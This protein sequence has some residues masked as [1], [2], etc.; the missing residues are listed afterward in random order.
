MHEVFQYGSKASRQLTLLVQSAALVAGWALWAPAGLGELRL[1]LVYVLAVWIVAGGVTLGTYL[2][3]SVA[4]FSEL[5]VEAWL[6]SA[7]A[8]WLVPGA[9][10]LASRWPVAVAVGLAVVVNS[11]RLLVSSRP[12]KGEGIVR[13]RRAAGNPE[14]PRLFRYQPAQAVFFSKETVPPML[15][16]LVLYTGVYALAGEYP[17]LAAGSFATV[18]AIWVGMSVARGA[19][20]ARVAARVPYLAPGILLTLLWTVTLTAVLLHTEIVLEGPVAKAP[21]I[22][23]GEAPETPGMTGRVLQRLMHVPPAPEAP[24][25]V[26]AQA[27]KSVTRMVDPG[28]AIGAKDQNGVPGVVLRPRPKR[29]QRPPLIVPGAR[30][31]VA[32]GRPLVIP[33]TGE[34]QLY[35]T[36]S[37]EL[38]AG[39]IVDPGSPLERVYGTTNGGAMD[40]VA[41]QMFEPPLDLSNCGKVMVA[42]I[43]AETMPLL[44]S[45]QLVAESSVE[46]AGTE[47]MGMKREETLEFQVPHTGKRLLIHAIRITFQRPAIDRNK[48][49]RVLLQRFTLE[50]R[51]HSGLTQQ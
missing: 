3:F 29:T 21:L 37:G 1:A 10:L 25:Q 9:L 16:A 35:R 19:L 11:T 47:L 17:L 18:T 24:S 50:S 38:P 32:S 36:S 34:Y 5:L 31:Q 26:E 30:L 33:F 6:A 46:D 44:A 23:I 48:N 41:V 20:D 39:S 49:V 8:M 40:T 22:D 12:P 45:M 15:G 13:K 43:S 51:G 28:P 4:P 42:L 14:P 27:T 7:N 2:A